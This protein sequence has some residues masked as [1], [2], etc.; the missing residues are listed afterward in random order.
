M[1]E[2]ADKILRALRG[3]DGRFMS[4]HNLLHVHDAPGCVT[5]ISLDV[6]D[7]WPLTINETYLQRLEEATTAAEYW[8]IVREEFGDW[9][10]EVLEKLGPPPLKGCGERER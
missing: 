5:V 8:A 4:E 2:Q 9:V 6:P 1:G 7:D 3:H 10:V